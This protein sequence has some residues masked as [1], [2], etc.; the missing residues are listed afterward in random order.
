[1]FYVHPY[2]GKISNLTDIFQ[3]GWFNHQ[4]GINLPYLVGH[5]SL[6]EAKDQENWNRSPAQGPNQVSFKVSPKL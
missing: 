5:F 6:I 4:L 1:M 3:L 2:L